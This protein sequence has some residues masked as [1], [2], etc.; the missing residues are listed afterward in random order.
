M[1]S[2]FF[3]LQFVLCSFKAGLLTIYSTITTVRH[4]VLS[5][6]FPET[7]FK[8]RNMLASKKICCEYFDIVRVKNA[9]K[10]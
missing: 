8:V 7:H 1:Q 9:Q 2:F 5:T 4:F 6:V 10:H 3:G